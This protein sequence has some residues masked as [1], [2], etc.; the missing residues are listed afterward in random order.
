MDENEL[1]GLLGKFIELTLNYYYDYQDQSVSRKRFRMNSLSFNI[2]FRLYM[3]REKKLTIMDLSEKMQISKPQLIK[4]VNTLEDEKLVI[5]ER[6]RENRRIVYLSLNENGVIY[7][8]G[9]LDGLKHSFCEKLL[10]QKAIDQDRLADALLKIT[11]AM[12]N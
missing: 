6:F 12:D 7:I 8:N 10:Q 11:T 1:K 2:L 9:I 4:L 3:S 5:R